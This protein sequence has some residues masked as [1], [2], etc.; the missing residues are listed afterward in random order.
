MGT[1]NI[2]EFAVQARDAGNN[3]APLADIS[4][5]VAVQNI[6]ISGTHAESAAFNARTGMIRVRTDAACAIL[7]AAAPVAETTD[8]PLDANAPEYFGVALNGSLKL[9][10]ITI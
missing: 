8:T 4:K 3:L 10:A 1:L 7:C 2:T 9:S 6:T 5:V